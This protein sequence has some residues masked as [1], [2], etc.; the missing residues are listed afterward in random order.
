MLADERYR[1]IL[2]L[3]KENGSVSAS[4]LNKKMNVSSE[5]IRRD[6]YYLE[7]KNMLRRVH[8]GAVAVTKMSEFKVLEKRL[9][10]NVEEKVECAKNALK[11]IKNGDVIFVDSGSTAIEFAEALKGRFENLT[12]ITNSLDVYKHLGN[13]G[14]KLIIIGGEYLAQEEAN[15]G[16]FAVEM[17]NNMHA[18]K[19]FVFP[20][21]V[22]LKNGVMS[23]EMDLYSVQCAYKN[24]ADRVIF[25]ADSSKFEKSGLAK[26]CDMDIQ[27]EFVTDSKINH[28]IYQMYRENNIKI[29]KGGKNEK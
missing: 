5:T 15:C 20:S 14:Y 18:D 17:I 13:S 29:V 23:C 8:G 24:N 2:G 3:I 21:A 11:L 4:Q 25:V 12:V 1:I 9:D 28:E 7:S 10:E 19:A 27:Y 26:I 16:F 22:S 6:L